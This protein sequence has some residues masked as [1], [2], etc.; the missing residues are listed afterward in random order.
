M[1]KTGAF[2]N[3]SDINGLIFF[4]SDIPLIFSNSNRPNTYQTQHIFNHLIICK[5]TQIHQHNKS[6]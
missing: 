1:L 5:L 4:H 3:N 6:T 2:F